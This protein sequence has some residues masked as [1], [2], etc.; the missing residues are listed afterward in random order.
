M[1]PTLLPWPPQTPLLLCPP[2]AGGLSAAKAGAAVS[3]IRAII[4]IIINTNKDI[5]LIRR[6]SLLRCRLIPDG[7]KL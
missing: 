7:A 2:T 6:T 1:T 5:R 3:P 4:A